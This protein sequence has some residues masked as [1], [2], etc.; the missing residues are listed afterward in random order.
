MRKLSLLFTLAVL[1]LATTAFADNIIFDL[2]PTNGTTSRDAGN[3]TGQGVSVQTTQTL[4]DM[5]FFLDL[6]NGG[7]LKFF[8]Y[9]GTNTN[10]L[11]LNTLTNVAPIQNMTWVSAP[12]NFTLQAGQT[13]YFGVISDAH[14]DYGYIFPPIN[15]SNNGLT[16]ITT[17]NSNYSGY[18]IPTFSGNGAAEIGLRL[19]ANAVP[20]PGSMVLLGTGALGLAG[21]LRRKLM[22]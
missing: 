3:G 6:P 13:Y 16:A 21:V 17:G 9:D 15:Y 5:E 11:Y 14:A 19:S 12:V 8:I 18:D 1:C 2:S 20:E 4:S 7:D 22:L 10:L